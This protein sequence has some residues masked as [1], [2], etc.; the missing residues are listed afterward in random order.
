[1]AH[2]KEESGLPIDQYNKSTP[3]GWQEGVPHYPFRLYRQKLALWHA[4][5]DLQPHQLGPAIAG[6]LR[7]RLFNLAMSLQFALPDG[8]V[9]AE[10][11]ALS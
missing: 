3:P 8:T 2:T 9:L 5:T 10:T 1:M 6:R 11:Q 4:L 7:G